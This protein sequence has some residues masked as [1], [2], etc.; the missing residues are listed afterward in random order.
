MAT[1]A[2]TVES[3]GERLVRFIWAGLLNG[4]DG[5]PVDWAAYADRSVQV[6]G[7]FGV[8]GSVTLEGSNDERNGTA[9]W[10]ALSDLRGNTF[11]LT[12]AKIE[13]IEDLTYK[14]RP[15]VTA[16]DGTTNLTVVV[17]ARKVI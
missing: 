16:G 11:A 14:L 4:D 13:Q 17:F 9:T 1:R 6:F 2:V 5:A 8:G 15:R 12:S 10:S 3:I 7:T